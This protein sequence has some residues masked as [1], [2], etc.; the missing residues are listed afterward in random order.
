MTDINAVNTN[1]IAA[2]SQHM[3]PE[4]KARWVAELRSGRHV[5]GK[6]RLRNSDGSMCCL[7]ILHGVC[8]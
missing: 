5:Q 2:N 1:P 3:N 7:G 4:I 8:V 6:G